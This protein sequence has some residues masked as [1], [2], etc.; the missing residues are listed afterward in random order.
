MIAE[1]YKVDFI[2][3]DG[4]LYFVF[5]DQLNYWQRIYKNVNVIETV[6]NIAMQMDEGT[7]PRK[8]SKGIL[9]YINTHLSNKNASY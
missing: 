9:R 7:I 1:D 3:K 8:T 4:G 6:E 2:L 5:A